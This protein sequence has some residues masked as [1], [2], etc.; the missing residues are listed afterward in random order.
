MPNEV[1]YALAAIGTYLVGA[2]PFGL[3]L[4]RLIKGVD[5]REVG[6]KN[7]G[8]T[9]AARVMGTF[10]FFPIF[11]LDLLKG[12]A[13]VFW[14]A[15]WIARAYPCNHCPAL[16]ACMA[17]LLSVVSGAGHLF[18]IWLGF[19]GGKGAATGVGV[20]FGLNWVAGIIAMLCFLLMISTTRMVSLGSMAGA[21]A[22]PIVNICYGNRWRFDMIQ[23]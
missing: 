16:E 17:V 7:I 13:P 5:L 6:S 20:V 11:L 10:W 12:F 21:V 19:K 9:N 3:V 22:A 4:A 8:A 18:P 1:I 2:I 14:V 15:P 23:K